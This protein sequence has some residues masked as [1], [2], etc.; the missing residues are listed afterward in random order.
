MLP[1][2]LPDPIDTEMTV[3]HSYMLPGTSIHN[4]DVSR[5]EHSLPLAPEPDSAGSYS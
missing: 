2:C 4:L 3:C 1:L 5:Y